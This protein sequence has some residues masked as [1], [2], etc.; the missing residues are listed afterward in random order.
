MKGVSV[1]QYGKTYTLTKNKFK[2]TGYVF[3]GWNTKKNGKGDFY[4]DGEDIRNITAKNGKTVTLYAQWSKKQYTIKYV[5]DGGTISS[6]NPTGYYYDTPT[7]QLAA[8][9][10]EGYTFKDGIR[11]LH[12]KTR[13]RRSKREPVK[14]TNCMQNGRSILTISCLTEMEQL[15][16]R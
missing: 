16:V 14:I 10:K 3:E 5:L 9:A 11:I 7:I 6:E 12:L 1:C 4:E 8:A 13:S 2:R 15:V